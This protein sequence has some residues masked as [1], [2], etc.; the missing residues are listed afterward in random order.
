MYRANFNYVIVRILTTRRYCFFFFYEYIAYGE[1]DHKIASR[2]NIVD[3]TRG[4]R[5][6]DLPPPPSRSA[7]RIFRGRVGQR[8]YVQ[9][10]QRQWHVKSRVSTFYYFM[11][12]VKFGFCE[13]HES[14]IWLWRE[15]QVGH[16]RY[17]TVNHR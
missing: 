12:W 6:Y 16:P 8:G 13:Q 15:P 3:G 14:R 4:L 10:P 9:R 1:T 11:R 17:N 7:F 2:Q 5:F